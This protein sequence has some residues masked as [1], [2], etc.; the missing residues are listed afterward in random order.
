MVPP[1]ASIAA[2]APL[3]TPI[4]TSLTFFSIFAGQEDFCTQRLVRNHAG[5]LQRSEINCVHRHRGNFRKTHLH[6]V[7]ARQ[8][9]ETTLGQTTLQRH[10]ATFKTHLVETTRTRLL[11]FMSATGSFAQARTDTATDAAAILGG[12]L[13]RA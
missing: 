5:L 11:P 9:D 13:R 12:A 6:D 1:A 4:P 10:L 8:R 7:V 2:L 3:V